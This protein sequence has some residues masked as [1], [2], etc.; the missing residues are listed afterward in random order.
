MEDVP[1]PVLLCCRCGEPETGRRLVQLAVRGSLAEVC[2]RCFLLEQLGE[3][4]KALPEGGVTRVIVEEGLQTLYELTRSRHSELLS[5]SL[6]DGAEEGE[7]GGRR[8]SRGS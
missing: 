8:E 1:P 4:T 6:E 3:L 5:R 2:Q 7:S